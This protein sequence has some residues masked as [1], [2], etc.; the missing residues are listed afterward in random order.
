V[1]ADAGLLQLAEAVRRA[2]IT[3]A[4]EGYQG[5]AISGLCGEGAQ[6]AAL[7][8]I[9]MVDLEKLIQQLTPSANEGTPPG[10]P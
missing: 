7:G 1:T 8:A 2:C 10:I 3:A 9:E 5:A 4:R 6:E